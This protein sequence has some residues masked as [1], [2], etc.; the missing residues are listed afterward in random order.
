ML[1]LPNGLEIVGDN[2]FAGSGI[3]K[4]FIPNTVRKLGSSAFVCCEE[5]REVVFE[6]GSQLETIGDSCFGYCMFEKI[7]IPKSVRDIG[8]EAFSGCEYLRSLVF[9]D[10]SQL[11]HVGEDALTYTPLEGEKGLFP[12]T[13]R[14]DGDAGAHQ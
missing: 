1:R 12:G 11:K 13:E 10:G 7:V 9:E 6:P 14:A 3:E 2:W 4:V 5:L 8:D